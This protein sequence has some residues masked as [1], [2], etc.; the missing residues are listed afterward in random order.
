MGDFRWNYPAVVHGNM[1]FPEAMPGGDGRAGHALLY[2]N[3][4]K[5]RILGDNAPPDLLRPSRTKRLLAA[6]KQALR[7]LTPPRGFWATRQ[8]VVRGTVS[9][10]IRE[11]AGVTCAVHTYPQGVP[12]RP[13][14]APVGSRR[15][16]GGN[17][18]DGPRK[19]GVEGPI[20]GRLVDARP[21]RMGQGKDPYEE[22]K[23]REAWQSHNKCL[24]KE[25]KGGA[26]RFGGLGMERRERAKWCGEA[27]VLSDAQCRYGLRR[28]DLSTEMI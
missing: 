23:A 22:H 20:V 21:R 10:R 7:P 17:P 14:S 1:D 4:V 25:S 18:R 24:P 2:G 3:E 16:P 26:Q 8:E 28:H 27:R 15:P 13:T 9:Q 5:A 11:D 6:S 12:M 19:A